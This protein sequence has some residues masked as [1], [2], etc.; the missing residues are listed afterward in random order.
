MKHDDFLPLVMPARRRR[1][2]DILLLR[3][4]GSSPHTALV[5]TR[6][7]QLV[8]VIPAGSRRVLS[9]YLDLPCEV[10]EVDGR[11]RRMLLAT[12]LESRDTGHFFQ[13]E[14]Q[15]MYQVF[16]PERIALELDDALGEFENLIRAALSSAAHGLSLDQISLLKQ[17]ISELF[18]EGS[19]LKNRATALG[20]RLKRVDIDVDSS[21]A[22]RYFMESLKELQRE[23]PMMWRFYCESLDP[24][25]SF[26][27]QVGG[28]YKS[29][30]RVVSGSEPN[31]VDGLEFGL[32]NA[33]ERAIK[34]VAVEFAPKE[35]REA[36]NAMTEALSTSPVLL[37]ELAAAEV[38]LLRPAVEIQPARP[39]LIDTMRTR[40]ALPAPG[41][42]SGTDA[43]DWLLPPPLEPELAAPAHIPLATTALVSETP[44]YGYSPPVMPALVTPP[45][46]TRDDDDPNHKL[47]QDEEVEEPAETALAVAEVPLE[48]G[49][50]PGW[51]VDHA[52]FGAQQPDLEH[53]KHIPEWLRRWH[54]QP[55]AQHARNPA[56]PPEELTLDDV[57]LYDEALLSEQTSASNMAYEPDE[58][59]AYPESLNEQLANLHVQ[60]TE[61]TESGLA[62]TPDKQ[63]D[64]SSLQEMT[65]Q[66]LHWLRLLRSDG[67]A[68]FERWATVLIEQ[69]NRL[70]A[71]LSGLI[72]DPQILAGAE[73]P[74]Y[75]R[76]LAEELH[77]MVV[78]PNPPQWLQDGTSNAAPPPEPELPEWLG[79][80]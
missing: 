11:E 20:L 55:R 6:R 29:R 53:E 70:P 52:L 17:S 74:T 50:V 73:N 24:R 71:I 9:D 64:W 63:T 57:T 12:A 79:L 62:P 43:F 16:Q 33:I 4:L 58:D 13:A 35:Y 78:I 26:E 80:R 31:G 28:F 10:I 47:W 8:G 30:R 37:A 40:L 27:I 5:L 69:P 45:A 68:E 2:A 14:I 21:E 51:L 38:D 19:L 3:P 48:P 34:R 61:A 42:E 56:T 46:N 66:V 22:D 44:H 77:G 60:P 65:N 32:R 36:A 76:A 59:L 67:D 39:M 7:G 41:A 1:W 54:E 49:T 23:R 15:L 25:I 72:R 18:E 75:Q